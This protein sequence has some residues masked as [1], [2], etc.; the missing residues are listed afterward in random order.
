MT[1]PFDADYFLRGK[2]TGKSLYS[3]YRWLPELTIPMA[4]AM[5]SHLGIKP[6]DTIFD[7]GCARGYVVKAFRKLGYHAYGYDSSEWAVENADPDVCHY[8]TRSEDIAFREVSYQ[9]VIAKDV[10]EHIPD[11]AGTIARLMTSAQTGVFAVV[12]LSAVDGERYVVGCYEKDPTHVH[13]LT[14][15][16]WAA[17]FIRPGWRVE[18]GYRVKGVKD[19]YF[20]PKYAAGNGFIVARRVGG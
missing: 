14:L 6:S 10:L 15:A 19:N 7:F 5:I 20:R 3:D 18:V 17:L 4:C 9:W 12:P 1:E 13:R 2:E 16:T 11:V 8:L